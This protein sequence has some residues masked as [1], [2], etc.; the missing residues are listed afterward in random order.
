MNSQ[1]HR[2]LYV[3]AEDDEASRF[4]DRR[5]AEEYRLAER[6]VNP[7]DGSPMQ[8]VLAGEFIMG[9]T[10]AEIEA[11]RRL[12]GNGDSFALEHEMPQFRPVVG[13]FYIGVFAVTNAQYARFLNAVRPEPAQFKRWLPGASQIQPPAAGAEI[14]AVDPGCERY[15]VVHV[16]WSGAEAYCHWANVR[17]PK[18]VEWE[19]A[20][21]GTDG[22]LFPWGNEWHDDC[23][24]WRREPAADAAATAPV[25]A[26]PQGRSPYGIYQM[27]GNVEEWCADPY[28][29]DASHAYAQ[30]DSL[31]PQNGQ[32]R[33]VR[34]GSCLGRHP[35]EF[36]CAMRRASAPDRVVKKCVGFRCVNGELHWAKQ[37]GSST[38]ESQPTP[39][40][41]IV[42]LPEVGTAAP[43][44]TASG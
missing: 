19:K 2:S 27:A 37:G 43:A 29:P 25:D 35:L 23:L 12:S 38:E 8:L 18:E 3:T 13:A 39:K 42:P 17:L 16:S 28:R 21:R 36:R 5:E 6:W 7:R 14:F 15:P 4:L 20:A 1:G 24:Q 31:L 30:G 32:G 11:A 33:V 40:P 9:S 10:P 26:F 44:A 34:G 41:V 22:R